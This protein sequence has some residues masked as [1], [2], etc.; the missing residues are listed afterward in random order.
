MGFLISNKG[1]AVDPRKVQAVL[2]W[3]QPKTVFEIQSFLGFASFYHKFIKHFSTTAAPFTKCLKRRKFG[4]GDSQMESFS[5]LKHLLS[6]TPVIVSQI[7]ST[8]VFGFPDFS[9]PFEFFS[10]TL[11]EA[12]S[13]LEHL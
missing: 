5:Q 1:V 11:G 3:P 7:C 13:K 2:D 4:W 10:E 9:E 6:S 8:P 12:P